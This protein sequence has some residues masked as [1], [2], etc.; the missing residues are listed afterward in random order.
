MSKDSTAPR[1]DI[2]GYAYRPSLLGAPWEFKL[3][4]GAIEWEAGRK[5]GRVALR[6]IRRIR[7]S[8][9]PANMQTQRFVTEIWADDAPKLQIV[10]CSWKSMV[11][12]E[13]LDGPY[14]AFVR[15]LHARVVQSGARPRFERGS[16]PL[17]YWPGLVVFAGV[18]LG[19]LALIARALQAQAMGGAAFYRHLLHIVFVA[20]RKLLPPQ[21]A[22]RL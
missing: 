3:T 13:R 5:T 8:F 22:G 11:V 16:H 7:L 21:C 2:T 9:R 10:S 12:Q 6:D 15:E 17:V 18:T 4:S 1:A 19:L 20:R 14:S